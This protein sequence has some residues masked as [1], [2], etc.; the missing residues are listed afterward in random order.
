M[1]PAWPN[2]VMVL[3]GGRLGARLRSALDERTARRRLRRR[4]LVATRRLS[5][6]AVGCSLDSSLLLMLPL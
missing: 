3:V 4:F 5:S 2:E 1:L 6:A